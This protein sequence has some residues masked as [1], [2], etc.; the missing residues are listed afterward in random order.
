MAGGQGTRLGHNGPK[1]TYD[2]GLPSHK[3]LFEILCDG[4]K[5]TMQKCGVAVPWYIMTSRE[6]NDETVSFFEKIITL[7]TLK[8]QLECS[9]SK[10]NFL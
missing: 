5:E 7:D 9:L 6:N 2:L 1:G 8:K 10:E 3:S 4:L